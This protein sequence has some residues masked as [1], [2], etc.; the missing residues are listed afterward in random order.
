MS[1]PEYLQA[2]LKYMRRYVGGQKSSS[3]LSGSLSVP[4]E[5]IYAF[6]GDGNVVVAR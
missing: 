5:S 1:H 6:D 4:V 2:L 3:A